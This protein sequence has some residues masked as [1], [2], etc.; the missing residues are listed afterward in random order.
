MEGRKEEQQ[1]GWKKEGI[2]VI[3]VGRKEEG[4]V[5]ALKGRVKGRKK[6]TMEGNIFKY[7]SLL[8]LYSVV[9]ESDVGLLSF[10]ADA[11]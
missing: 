10:T 6:R 9:I 1:E 11:K 7:Q 4:R 5:V 8:L 2:H 3:K